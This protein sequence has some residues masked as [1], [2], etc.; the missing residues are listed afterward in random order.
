MKKYRIT[1]H[2][3]SSYSDIVHIERKTFFGWKAIEGFNNNTTHTLTNKLDI[4][5]ERLLNYIEFGG[6]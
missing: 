6:K 3:D 1:I 2:R 4:A 5:H